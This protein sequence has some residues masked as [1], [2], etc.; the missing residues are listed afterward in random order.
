MNEMGLFH[1]IG[2]ERFNMGMSG[3][4]E[5][6]ECGELENENWPIHLSNFDPKLDQYITAIKNLPRFWDIFTTFMLN[7]PKFGRFFR[8]HLPEGWKW[9]PISWHIP[10]TSCHLSTPSGADTPFEMKHYYHS[11][12]RSNYKYCTQWD[13]AIL[14]PIGILC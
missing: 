3:P 11:I 14:F 10:N 12:K 5:E 2:L 7:L 6:F 8:F 13:S 4:K 1:N 9:D